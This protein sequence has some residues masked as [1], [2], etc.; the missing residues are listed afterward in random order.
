[1]QVC[2]SLQTDNHA[3]TSPLS[4]LQAGCP[5]CRPTNSLTALKAVE[6]WK[7]KL[8]K[9]RVMLP[10]R[11]GRTIQLVC[12]LCCRQFYNFELW[13]SQDG[14]T[15]GYRCSQ[16]EAFISGRGWWF[17]C[18]WVHW[19]TYQRC[20]WFLYSQ[21]R[22]V[23]WSQTSELG[24]CERGTSRCMLAILLIICFIAT[25]TSY[26]QI[27]QSFICLKLNRN[28]HT[29][30]TTTTT[31]QQRRPFNGLWSGTTRVGRYQKKHSPTHTH[32]YYYTC[33]CNCRFKPNRP[34]F[35]APLRLTASSYFKMIFGTRKLGSLTHCC[36]V[37]FV[38]LCVA[39]FGTTLTCDGRMD[40]QTHWWTDSNSICEINMILACSSC[41]NKKLSYRRRTVRC[42]VSIK[43]LPVV[44]QQCRNYLYDKS[45]RNRWYEVGD[46]VGG[47]AW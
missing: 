35:D 44:T 24:G 11:V 6:Q 43:I 28:I 21:W 19:D 9:P 18:I 38:F 16:G 40:R 34:A 10:G 41:G 1:M 8:D 36:V 3:S 37:Y 30:T 5:S 46:L 39:I 17:L 22:L 32:Y 14:F 29:T 27:G 12:I 26:L 13:V 31:Q 4:F 42:V 15:I 45:W 25:E 7:G 20:W 47:N 33:N 2:T 23:C